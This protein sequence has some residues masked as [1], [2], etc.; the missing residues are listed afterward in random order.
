VA[1]EDLTGKQRH[2]VDAYIGE[3][4]CC[5]SAA[6]IKAGYP[7]RSA[8]SIGWENLRKPEI[9]DAINARMLEL[10]MPPEEILSRLTEH[11]RGN[12]LDITGESG[13]LP[14][15]L[16]GLTR[17]QAALIKKFQVKETKF[18]ENVSVEIHDSQAALLA[19]AKRYD[20]FPD[21]LNVDVDE[22]DGAIAAGLAHLAGKQEEAAPR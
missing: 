4:N 20:L 16:A 17:Q 6:A 22:L 9:R 10:T 21:R 2:F 5:A 11:A 14:S 15:T 13:R 12:L 18:G 3:C 7:A 8:A 1:Y 19:L